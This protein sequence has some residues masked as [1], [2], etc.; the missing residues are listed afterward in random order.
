M[1]NHIVNVPLSKIREI[2]RHS[3][4][5]YWKPMILALLIY[6]FISSGVGIILDYF[7]TLNVPYGEA[8]YLDMPYGAS[9]YTFIVGGPL[10]FGLT[11]FLLSFFRDNYKN[12]TLLFE[13]FSHFGKSFML[14]LLITVKTFLWSMLL[15]IPGI[16]A[17]YRY[18]QA[19]YI[20][21]DN[22][23]LTPGQ[24]IKESCRIMDGNKATYFLLSLTF[25]GWIL[26]ATIPA[27]VYVFAAS[28]GA[29]TFGSAIISIVVGLPELIVDVYMLVAYTAFYEIATGRL[30]VVEKPENEQPDIIE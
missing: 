12:P 9:I 2:A 14:M 28:S 17:M 21:I 22:P 3:L 4:A 10:E 8:L 16:I 25:I 19:F 13:G 1:G 30:V 23:E 7:F 5:G 27:A 18:S 29:N 20:M 11:M 6:Y 24:C 26:L 15:F